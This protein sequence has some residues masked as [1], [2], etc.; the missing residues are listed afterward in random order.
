MR[1]TVAL[2]LALVM[3][4]LVG[5][6]S[7]PAPT[8]TPAP[9]PKKD[10]VIRI[11]VGTD[12]KNL[13]PGISTGVPEANIEL[14][15][16]E[17]L[18]RL[19]KDGRAV[20]GLAAAMPEVKDGG[21]TYVFK[22]R[23]GIKWSNG[24]P[25]TA[26]DFV[27]SWKRALDPM[28]ASEYSYQLYYI[29]GG[30]ALNTIPLNK[31][32]EKGKEIL[33]AN[34]KPTPRPDADVKADIKKMADAL[35][36]KAVDAKTIEIKLEAPSPYFLSL[37]A[38]HTLRPV[39]RKTVEAN[40][41]D[42]FRKPETMVTSGP[43]TLKSWA[44]KDKIVLVKNPGY[45]DAAKVKLDRIEYYL[46]DNETTVTQMYESGQ[47][48]IVESGVSNAELPRLKKE[49]PNDLKILPDLGTYYYRFNTTKAPTNDAKV[50]K[51]LTLAID[52]KAIVENITK[53]GQIPATAFVPSGIP[54]V[55]GDFRANGKDFFKDNDVEA[56]KKLL[57]DAGYPDGKGFPKLTILYNT[58]EG[59]KKIAEAIQE[60]WKKNLGITVELTQQ[61]WA[62]YLDSQAKL[63]YQ[64]SR[65]GWIGDYI[66]PMTFI[67]MWVTGGGNNQTGWTNKAYDDLVK[68]AKATD[69][70]KIRMTAQHDA[71]KILM[72][73]MPIMPIYFYVRVRLVNPK[74]KNW[75][76]PLT[77]GM[78][79]REAFVE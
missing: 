65:A 49:K 47:L 50:R 16:Y 46:V 64:V 13:D 28:T 2:L 56:A 15:L 27:W 53:A 11:N 70:Q 51:A 29:K 76:E 38:F 36:V 68:K 14:Q 57:A 69:D 22:L 23:D 54:D 10:M 20:P 44:P 31:V 12:P 42:F 45:Y 26:E 63:N 78:D 5:C 55:S 4:V 1:R 18:M 6:T 40:P 21:A 17:G 33:D 75:A 66:D 72:D 79:L 74:V 60:M 67:D 39:H 34:K 7:K 37:L 41:T 19:D 9:E 62:V 52:R 3:V 24:D 59:H 25:I 73:E 71:E 61:E 8:A 58:S 77:S 43:F 48:D 30:E 32:D 35:G